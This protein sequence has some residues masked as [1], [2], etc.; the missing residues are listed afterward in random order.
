MGG[1]EE[2]KRLVM[3]DIVVKRDSVSYET[4]FLLGDI[5]DSVASLPSAPRTVDATGLGTT[6]TFDLFYP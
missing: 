1:V 6:D 3:C 5:V 2:S 4:W